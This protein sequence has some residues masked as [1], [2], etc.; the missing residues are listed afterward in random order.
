MKFPYHGQK[1]KP[2]VITECCNLTGKGVYCPPDV[3][4]KDF[5]VI[6]VRNELFST[7][8]RPPLGSSLDLGDTNAIP[9]FGWPT[10]RH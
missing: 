1:T 10:L 4:M 9:M 6:G 3:F 2:F 8:G 5:A 7:L